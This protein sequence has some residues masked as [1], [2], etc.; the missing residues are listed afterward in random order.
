VQGQ[1]WPL[2]EHSRFVSV[3][4][5]GWH[6]QILGSG[7]PLLLVHGTGAST[8]SFRD[9]MSLWASRFTVVAVD[10]PGHGFSSAE[11]WFL[12]SL[13]AIAAELSNLLNTLGLQPVVAIGH[14][15]GAAI[16]ARMA[17]D[18]RITPRL[19][20]SLAGALV[21][22]RGLSQAWM[23]PAARLLARS[24]LA[25]QLIALRAHRIESVERLVASTGST[26]D[27]RGID[28][29]RRLASHPPHVA[30]MLAL[31]A[32]WDL[33]P[34]YDDLPRLR[35]RLLLL[36]GA[37]DRAIPLA[38]QREVAAHIPAAR[39]HIVERTGHL[40]HEEQPA[41]IARLVLAHLDGG[42]D[43]S[44]RSPGP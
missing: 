10:L 18:G 33:Q 26:L 42:D 37:E 3:G 1:D 43:P 11:P 12:P 4:P 39:L 22:L 19:L 23:M 15:A 20:V 8:H 35:T 44:A 21:P 9:L 16:G 28:L 32:A 6:V 34:L 29:Y 2:H 41:A 7:P 5:I 38:Q 30:G 24:S 40:L 14:S 36:A 27:A 31:L 17:L 25:A 13:P